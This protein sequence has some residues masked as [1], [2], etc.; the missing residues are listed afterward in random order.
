MDTAIVYFELHH[1]RTN[2]IIKMDSLDIC[3]EYSLLAFSSR[4]EKY[5]GIGRLPDGHT[6]E[7]ISDAYNIHVIINEVKYKWSGKTD[8]KGN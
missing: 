2:K 1:K 5:D 7:N 8:R 3:D 6:A 4:E